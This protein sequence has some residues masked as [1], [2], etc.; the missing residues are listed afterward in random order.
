VIGFIPE[1][2]EVIRLL[3]HLKLWPIEYPEPGRVDAWS[4][5]FAF[6]LLRQFSD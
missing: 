3:R 5:P 2:Q 6:K 1:W 4:S